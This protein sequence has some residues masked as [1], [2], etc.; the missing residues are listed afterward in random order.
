MTK[1]SL[2][3]LNPL[4]KY[5]ED[6]LDDPS[7][8]DVYELMYGW[9]QNRKLLIKLFDNFEYLK[10]NI[11]KLVRIHIKSIIEND[12]KKNKSGKLPHLRIETTEK[13]RFQSVKLA[14]EANK[15]IREQNIS[16][17]KALAQIEVKNER[18]RLLDPQSKKL[19][20][21]AGRRIIGRQ[22]KGKR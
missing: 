13:Q 10:P 22:K 3:L 2:R 14:V 17:E 5:A 7:M 19:L 16:L 9:T 6:E 8:L 21:V 12:I 18:G 11:K 20:A 4:K 1:N 15:L